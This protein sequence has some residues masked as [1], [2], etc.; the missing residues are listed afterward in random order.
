M[1]KRK[2]LLLKIEDR[3]DFIE[4]HK[5]KIDKERMK[6]IPHEGLIS[7]W[8]GEIR[9]AQKSITRYNERLRRLG[10]KI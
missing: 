9:G 5:R 8:Q 1:G 7:H 3:N 2:K 6:P 4:I 10:W